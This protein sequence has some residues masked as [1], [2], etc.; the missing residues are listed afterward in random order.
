[1]A[2]AQRIARHA[3]RQPAAAA[4][5]LCAVG[6]APGSAQQAP[7]REVTDAFDQPLGD[8]WAA[9]GA[10]WQLVRGQLQGRG[11]G[12]L[13]LVDPWWQDVE[14]EVTVSL[15]DAQGPPYWAGIR[16]R[17][18]VTQGSGVG[19]LVY[20]RLNGSLEIWTEG[21]ILA[22]ADTGAAAALAR[23]DAFRL[24]ARVRGGHL[25]GL[26]NGKV[27]VQADDAAL[28][29]GEVSLAVCGCTATFDDFAARGSTAGGTIWGQ[30]V[31]SAD[32]LPVAGATVET[33]HSMDGYPSLALASTTTDDEGWYHLAGLPPGEKAYWVRACRER[34]GGGTGWFVTVS[35]ER[36]TRCDLSLLG[37]PPSAVWVDSPALGPRPP[38]EEVADPQCYGGSRA[39]LRLPA[40]EQPPELRCSFTV[41]REGL[42]VLRLGSGL[43]P[44]LHYWSPYVWRLD[45]GDWRDAA[46]SLTLGPRYGDRLSLVWA[47]GE[48]MRLTAG[49]HTL[50][51]RLSG[52]AP[53]GNYYWTFDALSIEQLPEPVAQETAHG[54]RP[55]LQWTSAAEDEMTLQ[56]SSEADFSEGTLTV[57]HLRGGEWQLPADL[58]LPDGSYHWRV[59]RLA[60]ED[61]DFRG[62]F[63]PAAHLAV[64]T[65]APAI[66]TVAGRASAPTAAVVSYATDR[67]CD[68]WVEWDCSAHSPRFRTAT[69]HGTQHRVRLNGLQPATCYRYWIVVRGEGGERR[70]LRRQFLTPRGALSGK[71]SPFGIFA[72]ALPYARQ[73]GEAGIR[74]VS[75]YWDWATLEP[76][77]G[78]FVWQQ[79]ADRMALA[80]R[81]GLN[82]TVTTWGTPRW[83]RPSHPDEHPAWDFTYGP[84][85]LEPAGEFF[86]ALAAHC[87]GRTGWFLPW[88]EPNV[89]RDPTFGYPRGYWASRPHAATYTAYQRA[90]YEGAKAG[91]PDC[92]FVG[93]N[94]AGVDLAFIEKCY[95][96]GAADS[97]D[98]MNVHYYAMLGD[99]EQQDPEGMFAG[100]RRLMARYGDAQKPIYCSEGGGTSSGLPGT[101][102][103]IQ[104]ANLVRIYIISIAN[105]VD[106]LCWTFS[107]DTQP[108]GGKKVE[109]VMW[110]GLFGFDPDPTHA[111]PDL[112]AQPK[113]SYFAYRTMAQLLEGSVYRRRLAVG[114]GVR[115]YRFGRRTAGGTR[116]AITAVWSEKAPKEVTIPLGGHLQRAVSH[117]GEPVEV[118]TDGDSA[119]LTATTAPVFLMAQRP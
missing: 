26:L 77:R 108:Y 60:P 75:D 99:F 22:A 115:A 76:Q 32:Q 13:M 62:T 42:Y 87:R 41:P 104:A 90:A 78:R 19:Y 18:D 63:S 66:T 95:D 89:A 55:V 80:E 88:I 71:Q 73:F 54:D 107:H 72:Q 11:T 84:D 5:L 23:G 65:G 10:D 30:V 6:A 110:M 106:K 64:K 24:G 17:A 44:A 111:I 59:K 52:P 56:L 2:R 53:G 68:T 4:L 47:G 102:E 105:G 12:D 96:E 35:D 49:E 27:L 16:L 85:D 34:C 21:R 58:R 37:H 116:E 91:N 36:P 25:E 109:M 39:V 83:I 61:S 92:H 38:L 82:L 70:S 33:Y 103:A 67:A 81:N 31:R 57:P 51:M 50:A 118:A 112:Q 117:L 113:P 101:D 97:F 114:A 9:V 1:M 43:Y 94:T 79:A 98:V 7:T 3:A 28:R 100:L 14:A 93:M 86:R 69:T 15:R 20:L 74:W 45:G 46:T 8:H 48:P 29:W 40:N 119:H